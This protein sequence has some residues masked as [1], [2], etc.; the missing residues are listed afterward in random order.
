MGRFE[1]AAEFYAHREPYPPELFAELAR[2]LPISG[3]ERLLDVGCGPAPIAIG[4]APYV[5]EVVA[6]DPEDAMLAVARAAIAK[7][8][9]SI[10]LVRS[11]LEDFSPPDRFDVVTI[12]RGLHWLDRERSL[13][14]LDRIATPRGAIIIAGSFTASDGNPWLE[15]WR[16]TWLAFTTEPLERYRIDPPAWFEDSR[17]HFAFDARVRARH[18]VT[19][20]SMIARSLSFSVTSPTVLGDR[21]AEFERSIADTLRPFAADDVLEEEVEASAFVFRAGAV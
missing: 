15:P 16:K 17:F 3:S 11:R 9:R 14:S 2:R 18:T 20:D 12:G 13:A 5:A 19:I 1:T 21:R 10:D 6:L 4:F 7:S 8:N